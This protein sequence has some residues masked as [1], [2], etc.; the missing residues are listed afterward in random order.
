M[1]VWPGR[2]QRFDKVWPWLLQDRAAGLAG[3]RRCLGLTD[4]G[5]SCEGLGPHQAEVPDPGVSGVTYMS[6]GHSDTHAHTLTSGVTHVQLGLLSR[7]MDTDV[8]AG[9]Y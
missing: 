7:H 4:R 2:G 9:M 6:N 1:A 3:G 5:L 8:H